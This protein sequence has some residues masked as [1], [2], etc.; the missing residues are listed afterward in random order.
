[1]EA[2][3]M[4]SLLDTKLV[5]YVGELF[6][7]LAD[8]AQR[9][10]ITLYRLLAEG[11]P[12]SRGVLAEKAGLPRERVDDILDDWRGVFYDAAGD[13]IG[14]WGLSLKEMHHR[15][16]IGG[17]TL[18]AWCAWDTLFLPQIIGEA[19]E[20][21]SACI[22]SGDPVRLT[23]GPEEIEKADPADAMVSFVT[24]GIADAEHDIQLSFC[25]HVYFFRSAAVAE[26]WLSERPGT[27]LLTLDEAWALGRK[28][29]A[30]QF[31]CALNPP[32]A[33]ESNRKRVAEARSCC[34]S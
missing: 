3:T 29:N 33:A 8:D 9:V 11:H 16:R 17:R 18:Y 19:A 32:V 1:M 30:I 2:W 10:S 28:K 6:P 15:F 25:H 14:Y 27:R 7:S 31:G 23:V 24:P 5:S 34:V 12:V 26:A 22:I 20:V 13:V 21:E 4:N